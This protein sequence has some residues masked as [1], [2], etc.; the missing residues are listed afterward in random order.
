MFWLAFGTAAAVIGLALMTIGVTRS[1]RGDNLLTS[2]WFDAGLGLLALGVLQL[3]WALR[4]YVGHRRV[5]ARATATGDSPA[6]LHV[7]SK[8]AE[9]EAVRGYFR[10]RE[11]LMDIWEKQEKDRRK[12]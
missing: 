9:L 3:L 6:G 4:L 1:A 11:K 10:E 7:D 2:L 12:D 8:S 5:E